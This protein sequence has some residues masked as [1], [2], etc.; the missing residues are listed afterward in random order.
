M[1]ELF[2]TDLLMS[3]AYHPQTD[4]QTERTNRTITLR[5]YVNRNGLN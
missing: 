3:T 5:N 4:S 2:G 1:Q